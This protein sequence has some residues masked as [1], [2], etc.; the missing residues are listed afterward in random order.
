M[1]PIVI[2][3]D[4]LKPSYNY[5]KF[6]MKPQ[7]LLYQPNI[8]SLQLLLNQELQGWNSCFSKYGMG[9]A[10]FNLAEPYNK[11]WR[12]YFSYCRQRR[13][14]SERLSESK[15]SEILWKLVKQW[16]PL[17]LS[18]FFLTPDLASSTMSPWIFKNVW[19]IYVFHSPQCKP[20][21]LWYIRRKIFL[22][23]QRTVLF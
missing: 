4:M 23:L 9:K 16:K 19:L 14:N 12:G 20:C 21:L 2:N 5:L 22:I 1:V 6:R 13:Q 17:T 3:K 7:L 11:K 18:Q 15:I 10:S 8:T